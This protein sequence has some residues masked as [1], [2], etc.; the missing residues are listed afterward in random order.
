MLRQQN[1]HDLNIRCPYCDTLLFRGDFI[2]NIK[3]PCSKC[4]THLQIEVNEQKGVNILK[5]IRDEPM[6]KVV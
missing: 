4:K 6:Q 5:Q 1:G 3:I 2:G